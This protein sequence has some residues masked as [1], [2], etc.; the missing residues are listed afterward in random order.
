MPDGYQFAGWKYGNKIYTTGE[1]LTINIADAGDDY[2]GKENDTNYVYVYA[3]YTKI[4]TTCVLY[5]ANGGL[6]T[7]TDLGTDITDNIQ[8]NIP[9]NKATTLSSGTGFTRAGYKLIGWNT[10]KDAADKGTVEWK[11]GE[12]VGVDGS[13]NTLYAVWKETANILVKKTDADGKQELTGAE[14]TLE[15]KNSSGTYEAVQGYDKDHPIAS[16]EG[17][18]EVDGLDDGDYQLTEVKSPAG[19]VAKTANTTFTVKNGEV[20]AGDK[21]TLNGKTVYVISIKN[22][23]GN[24]L[25]NTGGEGTWMYFAVGAALVLIAAIGGFVMR[26]RNHGKGGC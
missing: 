6:G 22:D 10:D 21:Q 18:V 12:T 24:P 8:R 14:F 15:K 26:R 19:Y 11:L 9:L 23:P 4:D 7:L 13:S 16:K 20:N 17:G 5:D 25:P 3:V 2:S 1:T